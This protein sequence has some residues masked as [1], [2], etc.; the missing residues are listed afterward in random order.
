MKAQEKAVHLDPITREEYDEIREAVSEF[1]AWQ[2]DYFPAHLKQCF[3]YAAS[4]IPYHELGEPIDFITNDALNETLLIDL[5]EA[6]ARIRKNHNTYVNLP[7]YEA[8]TRKPEKVD[9]TDLT[10]QERTDVQR[11]RTLKRV[12]DLLGDAKQMRQHRRILKEAFAGLKDEAALK[13]WEALDL[14]LDADIQYAE[15]LTAVD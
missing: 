7:E 2:G 8:L 14:Q 6:I 13:T 1:S 9:L 11:W 5:V 10:P 15:S 12:T 4:M 3:R